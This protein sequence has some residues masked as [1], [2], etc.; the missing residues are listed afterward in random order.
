MDEKSLT[1]VAMV[2]NILRSKGTANIGTV[3][4]SKSNHSKQDHSDELSKS[5]VKNFINCF[6]VSTVDMLI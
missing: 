6:F 1:A 5:L 2:Q 3:H 4:L